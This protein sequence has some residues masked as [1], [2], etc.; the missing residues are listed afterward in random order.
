MFLFF[1]FVL[2]H[3]QLLLFILATRFLF[4]L[5]PILVFA[6]LTFYL[7]CR[8]HSE[9]RGRSWRKLRGYQWYMRYLLTMDCA[10]FLF[11]VPCDLAT[12]M[13]FKWRIYIM[14]MITII[15]YRGETKWHYY[16]N[17]YLWQG[18]VITI[19]SVVW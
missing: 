8:W 2:L 6:R 13:V 10:L 12:Q 5:R 3:Y 11:V 19:C 1:I 16:Y 4:Q 7:L 18:N 15:I 9:C 17:I 14:K